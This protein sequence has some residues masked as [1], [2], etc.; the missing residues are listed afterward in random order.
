M[1]LLSAA[2]TESFFETFLSFFQGKFSWFLLGVY[3]HSIWV[4]GGNVPGRG[5][6]VEYDWGSG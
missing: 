3:V 5:G 6:G 2:K 1:T 4:L